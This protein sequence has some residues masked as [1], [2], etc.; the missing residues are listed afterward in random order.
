[1]NN[2]KTNFAS[3]LIAIAL[4]V[5]FVQLA[6]NTFFS[7]EKDLALEPPAVKSQNIDT[8]SKKIF[9]H[10]EKVT[11]EYDPDKN[12]AAKSRSQVKLMWESSFHSESFLNQSGEKWF[13][14]F[15]DGDKYNLRQTTLNV[16]RIKN[17]V[18]SDL[19]VSTSDSS[20]S[21]FLV[22][23]I[24]K[25]NKTEIPTVFADLDDDESDPTDTTIKP[26]ETKLDFNGLTYS[27]YVESPDNSESPTVGSKLYLQVG[28]KKQ[29]LRY[30]KNG[31][32]DCLWSL[33]W[34]GDLDQDGKLDLLLDLTQHYNVE[35]IVLFLS[36]KAEKG[37]LV[38]FVAD[39]YNVGC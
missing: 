9:I 31:C 16:K 22:R 30:L 32:N 38:K 12:K 21:V 1:M 10:N 26:S 28:E 8:E 37:N 19:E 4:G 3:F 11:A 7:V 39:F 35:D 36:S 29:V 6:N 18:L 14:L 5:G 34:A 15:R 2:L 25:F 13:G 24:L 17:P 33:I 23:D 27:L 20:R